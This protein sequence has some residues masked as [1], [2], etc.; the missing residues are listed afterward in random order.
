MP[1]N[2]KVLLQL[3]L[4]NQSLLINRF[5]TAVEVVSHMGAMQAQDYAMSKW[6][7]GIRLQNATDAL[8]Q[9]DLDSGNLV[10]THVLRPTWHIMAAQDARWI[11]ELSA[12]KL[13]QT[14]G[15]MY[16]QLELDDVLF[17]KANK[18]I[19]KVL[20]KG[21]DLTREEL[22]D[23]LANKGIQ[24]Q[25]V[26]AAHIMFRAELDKVVCNG[27]RRGKQ[28]TYSLF[29]RKIPAAQPISREEAL[30]K[31]TITYFRSRGPATVEDFSWWS[32]LSLTECRTG[33]Q[34]IQSQ[35]EKIKAGDTELYMTHPEFSRQ[36]IRRSLLFLP[37]YDE[38]LIAY[39]DRTASN[40]LFTKPVNKIFEP[41][42]VENGLV[43]GGWKRSL[44]KDCVLMQAEKPLRAVK[45]GALQKSAKRFGEFLE[46]PIKLSTSL[47]K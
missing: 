2:E 10:R 37:A 25:G 41:I 22:M 15:T 43:L 35:L 36:R 42:V 29:D 30:A 9:Q 23:A 38:F 46:L 40:Q 21:E 28:H 13:N 11:L 18:V 6:A 8:I 32:G 20:S 27:K 44:K 39:A 5:S 26:R 3:R 17:R 45:P 14:V 47:N 19:E 4:A 1:F 33:I 16:R 31:L 12:P 24:A 34:S 7:I